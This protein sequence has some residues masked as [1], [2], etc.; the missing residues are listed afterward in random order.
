MAGL[1]TT[2][3]LLSSWAVLLLAQNTPQNCIFSLVAEGNILGQAYEGVGGPACPADLGSGGSDSSSSSSSSS[4]GRYY[5]YLDLP[6]DMHRSGDA[7]RTVRTDVGVLNGFVCNNEGG[8]E[9]GGA[10]ATVTAT[11][12]AGSG[13]SSSGEGA[14]GAGA[15]TTSWDGVVETVTLTVPGTFETVTV[16]RGEGS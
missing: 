10:T 11:A 1:L 14:A 16:T 12:A 8:G 7:C 6:E 13:S 4:S 2:F 3:T 5:Y 15:V 9:G